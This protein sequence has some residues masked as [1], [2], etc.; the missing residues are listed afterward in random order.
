M[1]VV[2][3]TIACNV[4]SSATFLIQIPF[5]TCRRGFVW[6]VWSSF[7]GE[8]EAPPYTA[9]AITKPTFRVVTSECVNI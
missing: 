7:L 1:K 3:V 9:S 5:E 2:K 4:E 6:V 8:R